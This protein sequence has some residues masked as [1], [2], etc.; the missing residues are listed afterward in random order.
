MIDVIRPFLL[1][2]HTA[3]KVYTLMS[4]NFFKI[5][6]HSVVDAVETVSP[7]GVPSLG[8]ENFVSRLAVVPRFLTKEQYAALESQ[9]ENTTSIS[10]LVEYVNSMSISTLDSTLANGEEKMANY[11]IFDDTVENGWSLEGYDPSED[12]FGMEET[13][14]DLYH[15]DDFES[16]IKAI[17]DIDER[18][19]MLKKD[20][21][22]LEAWFNGLSK[23][24]R[25]RVGDVVRG[26]WEHDEWFKNLPTDQRDELVHKH[27]KIHE[28]LGDIV[29][30]TAGA[31]SYVWDDEYGLESAEE[32]GA[33]KARELYGKI[34]E[35]EAATT[36]AGEKAAEEL[37]KLKEEVEKRY[38][39][40]EKDPN[41]KEKQKALR[42]AVERYTALLKRVERVNEDIAR[43]AA[44]AMLGFF[45]RVWERVKDYGKAIKDFFAKHWKICAA[46]A[47]V[48]VAAGAAGAYAH[49]RSSR[50]R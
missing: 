35:R 24:Q 11:G 13:K 7:N 40:F 38:Q 30:G 32:A 14:D 45:K 4:S 18:T 29:G 46:I 17:D 28:R 41:S 21:D 22:K 16:T 42:E 8:L 26:D 10:A 19:S 5:L 23:E 3:K 44:R 1:C 2:V 48:T 15:P 37:K 25:D 43:R 49:H 12:V 50:R 47:G 27:A 6:G 20:D 31:E 33:K 34:G 36:K 39:E 9:K